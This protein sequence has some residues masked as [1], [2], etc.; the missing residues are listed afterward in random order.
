M[1]AIAALAFSLVGCSPAAGKVS[2]T[3]NVNGKPLEK[4]FISY[5]PA[6]NQGAPVTADVRQGK[7]EVETVAGKKLVQISAPVVVDRRPEF[8]GPDAPLMDITEES[9]PAK[10]NTDTTLSFDLPRG[11]STKD[12]NVESIRQRKK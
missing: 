7:Y 2:G 4:G 1:I 12:W 8:N 11:V 3:V 5:V 9:I 6:D 10:Y